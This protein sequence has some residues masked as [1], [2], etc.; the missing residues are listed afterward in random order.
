MR[1]LVRHQWVREHGTPRLSVLVGHVPTART[2]WND[3]IELSGRTVD[4][5]QTFEL[6]GG[7]GSRSHR[8]VVQKAIE[9]TIATPHRPSALVC[10]DEAAAFASAP[11]RVDAMLREGLVAIPPPRRA[12]R[13]N[14]ATGARERPPIDPRARSLAELT[15]FEAL[16]ATP[17]TAGRFQLNQRLTVRF[18]GADAEIDLLSRDD[19][20]AIEIDGYHHFG[21][22]ASYRRDRRKDLLLQSQGFLV[23]RVLAEDVHADPRGAVRM[24]SEAL[25]HRR[26]DAR[27]SR[28]S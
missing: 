19:K 21:D 17:G 14:V 9:E 26:R 2:L 13:R 28:G 23:V 18:G 1:V 16:E 4:Q 12:A 10:A 20:I 11:D 27:R 3:W 24:V 6:D 5:A 8:A 15:L 7:A 25:A 22:A